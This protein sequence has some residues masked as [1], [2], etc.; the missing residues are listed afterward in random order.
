MK[1]LFTG[2]FLFVFATSLSVQAQRENVNYDEEKVPQF[3]LLP[4]LVSE[5][6]KQISTVEEWEH[7]RRPELLKTF[8]GQMFGVTPE[9]KVNVS[10]EVLA[11]NPNAVAGKATCKQIR[12]L[13]K[14]GTVERKMQLLVYLPNQ[15]QGKIPL[16]IGYNFN[17]NQTIS[18]D[19][20]I[21]PSNDNERGIS[22]SRWPVDMIVSSG[23]GLATIWY[24]DLFP[25]KEDK[26]DESVLPLFGYTPE[27]SLSGS[28][29]QA[30]GA[31]A[32]GLSRAMDYFETDKDIDAS[33]VVLMGHSRNGKAALWAGVQD[34]RFAVVI[35]NDSGCGGAALS[36]R[37]FGETIDVITS[38]FPHWFCPD[39]RKYAK[40]EQDLPFDQHQLLALIAPRPLYVASAEDDKWADPKGEYL[41][42]FYAG[43]VYNLYGMKGLDTEAMP[44]VNQPVMNRVGYHIRTGEHDVTDYDW[45]NYIIFADKWLK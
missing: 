22:K 9:G 28:H 41:S 17:G 24:G 26:H 6:G 39:F 14:S 36:K 1:R 45:K 34:Q 2:L 32:W 30:I 16:F 35:S 29:W 40:K 44:L 43:E 42:A 10:Y 19:L 21:I 31:W 8:A 12:V 25:D 11:V 20:E 15:V 3:M 7:I 38:F 23:Y 4:L 37:E 27:T 33:K 5:S 13:F 18:E